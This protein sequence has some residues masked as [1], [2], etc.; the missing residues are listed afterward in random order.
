MPSP[1]PR[2]PSRNCTTPTPPLPKRK[3]PQSQYGQIVK[4]YEDTWNVKDNYVTNGDVFAPPIPIPAR[5]PPLPYRCGSPL[6][7]NSPATIRRQLLRSSA[8]IDTE[9][10]ATFSQH[11]QNHGLADRPS[12]YPL[13]TSHKILYSKNMSPLCSLSSSPS[14]SKNPFESPKVSD[15]VNGAFLSQLP[16]PPL[17]V[18]PPKSPQSTASVQLSNEC[19]SIKPEKKKETEVNIFQRKNDPFDDDF[20]TSL[21]RK[22]NQKKEHC[23]TSNSFTNV[24]A[25]NSSTKG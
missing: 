15:I 6:S 10:P 24:D 12:E 2:P 23:Q 9:S 3:L 5:K 7:T 4:N 19:K 22:S 14:R 17:P 8:S 20:F 1:P 18:R 13:N 25:N 21:P 16:L 11:S